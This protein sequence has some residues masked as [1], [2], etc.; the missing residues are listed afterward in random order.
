VALTLAPPDGEPD[1]DQLAA[2]LTR[3]ARPLFLGR[4]SCPPAGPVYGGE[5]MEAASLLEALRQ[6]PVRLRPGEPPPVGGLQA[7]IGLGPGQTQTEREWTVRPVN[8]L[9]DWRNQTHRGRRLVAEGLVSP[10][11]TETEGPL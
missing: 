1:L 7:Q 3:P 9:R 10:P 2:A 6:A 4:V 5:Q 11:A 8:D